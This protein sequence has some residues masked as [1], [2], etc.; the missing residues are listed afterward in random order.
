[1]SLSWLTK[2]VD[3]QERSRDI[4]LF[5]FITMSGKVKDKSTEICF[6]TFFYERGVWH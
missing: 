5:P 3:F 6:R 1:M 4:K 2:Q